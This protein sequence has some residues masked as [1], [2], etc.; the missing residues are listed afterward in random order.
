M[1][2]TISFAE[3]RAFL[4]DMGFVE[5]TVRGEFLRFQHHPSDTRFIFRAYR[6]TDRV[7]PGDLVAVRRFLDERGLMDPAE[8]ERFL[9]KTPA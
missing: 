4:H 5:D 2:R 9:S 6:P 3:L 7:N 1:A 8:F